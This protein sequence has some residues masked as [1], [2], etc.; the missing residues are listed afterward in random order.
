MARLFVARFQVLLQETEQLFFSSRVSLARSGRISAV[1][2]LVQACLYGKETDCMQLFLFA[3]K[4]L[5]NAALPVISD[6]SGASEA[7]AALKVALSAIPA[8]WRPASA[9]VATRICMGLLWCLRY[10][11]QWDELYQLAEEALLMTPKALHA[12]LMKLQILAL[13][14]QEPSELCSVVR[15]LARGEASSEAALLL[16]FARLSI[17][18]SITSFSAYEEALELVQADRGP[19]AANIHLEIAEGLLKRRRPWLKAWTHIRAALELALTFESQKKVSDGHRDCRTF[20]VRTC[21][22]L[23]SHSP[24]CLLSTLACC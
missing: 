2:H 18:K 23:A 1:R 11:G 4:A 16:F 3:A 12:A 14:H 22:D 5:W 8:S 19:Q 20:P 21:D 13:T 17:D 7:C 10:S 24:G 15:D 6:H 9:A